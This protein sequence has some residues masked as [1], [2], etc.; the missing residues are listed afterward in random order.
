MLDF[1]N[2]NFI[3]H[4]SGLFDANSIKELIAKFEQNNEKYISINNITDREKNAIDRGE[5]SD[6]LRLQ[7]YWY[8]IWKTSDNLLDFFKPYTYITFPPQVR[9]IKAI[10]NKVPWHQDIGYMRLATTK[11]PDQ[12]ITCFVPIELEPKNHSTIQF[13][14]DPR[15]LEELKHE[16]VGKFGAGITVNDFT[17]PFHFELNIGD[18]LVFGDYTIHRTFTPEGCNIERRSL[19]FRL[20]TPE[21]AIPNKDYFNLETMSFIN[22]NTNKENIYV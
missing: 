10:D 7:E 17:E 15:G 22:T 8:N 12:V 1:K 2:R 19:E 14:S 5:A 3:I 18:A 16:L 4:A 11:A 9:H 6:L 20:T 21:L 13:S